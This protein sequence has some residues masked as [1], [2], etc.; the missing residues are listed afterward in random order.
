M[1][2]VDVRLIQ[3]SQQSLSSFYG[4]NRLDSLR[5]GPKYRRLVGRISATPASHLHCLR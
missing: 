2:D 3:H 4:M 5:E 1:L